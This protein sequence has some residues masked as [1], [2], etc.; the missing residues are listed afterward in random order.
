MTRTNAREIAVHLVYSLHYFD[1]QADVLLEQLFEPE[2]YAKLGEASAVY[3]EQPDETQKAYIGAILRGVQD[4]LPELDGYIEQ[5]ATGWK[6]S[7]IS[8]IARAIMETA[9]YEA[10]YMDDVPVGAAINE[11]VELCKKYEE[12][13]TA[14][15]VNGILGS[16]AREVLGK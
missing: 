15:F 14:S 9:I 11:A 8:R 4:K 12:P 5:F 10:L 3:T 16:F 2:Y 13:E 7:R 6:L 1:E